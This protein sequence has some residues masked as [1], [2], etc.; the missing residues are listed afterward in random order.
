MA[1]NILRDIAATLIH[2]KDRALAVL[3]KLLANRF[4]IHRYGEMSN[5]SLDSLAK[6]IHAELRLKGEKHPIRIRA[7]YHLER[8]E[9][10]QAIVFDTV[11]TSREWVNLLIGDLTKERSL[12]A[13]LPP[14]VALAARVL[15]V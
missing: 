2:G 12:R 7:F 4:A 1:E 14:K 15:G 11:S 13:E 8:S 10:K 9:G 3:A 6:E 5:F